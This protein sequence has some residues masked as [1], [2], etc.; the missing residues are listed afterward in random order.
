MID[1]RYLGAGPASGLVRTGLV[2]ALALVFLASLPAAPGQ[3]GQTVYRVVGPDGQVSY[4]DTPPEKGQVEVVELKEA[5]TQPALEVAGKKGPATEAAN[6]YT[7]VEI[8]SPE[9]DSTVLPD[10]LNVMVQLELVPPLLDEHSVQ[11]FLDGEPQG[12]PAA[13]TAI[14]LGELYR[15]TRTILAKVLDDNGAVVA[16]S[17]VVAIHVKRHSVK[18]PSVKA[19]PPKPAPPK[20]TPPKPSPST[21]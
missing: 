14:A 11:F 20:P 15:G 19:T 13:A 1:S 10:Q 17:N 12:V 9:N 5:N 16:Q 6:P 21:P 2:P 7:K 3:A 18:H 4:T 8:I